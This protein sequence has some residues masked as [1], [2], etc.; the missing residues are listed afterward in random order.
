MAVVRV[1]PH[2]KLGLTKLAAISELST[3]FWIDQICINQDDIGER[4]HQVQLMPQIY[5]N[6]IR[7]VVWLRLR[8]SEWGANLKAQ[9]EDDEL[10]SFAKQVFLLGQETPDLGYKSE[11]TFTPIYRA[12]ETIEWNKRLPQVRGIERP[13]DLLLFGLPEVS[14]P[15]CI[16]LTNFFEAPWFSRIW[17]IQEVFF[18]RRVPYII[19]GCR[20]RNFLYILWAGAFISQNIT[21]FSKTST[22]DTIPIHARITE[23]ARLLLQLAFAR[24]HWTLG[25]LLWR[26]ANYGA[27]DQRDKYFALIS[28][29]SEFRNTELAPPST[30]AGLSEAGRRSESRFHALCH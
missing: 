20:L 25:S 1:T 27:S 13:D 22:V 24:S 8:C 30:A 12:E 6:A 2:L 29:A 23:H 16:Q 11:K 18:S 9:S 5:S 17:V 10:W 14:D 4:S 26:T 15:R 19:Y 21:I 28:L 3:W 7:T